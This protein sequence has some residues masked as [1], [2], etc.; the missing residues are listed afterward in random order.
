MALKELGCWN[1]LHKCDSVLYFCVFGE[2]HT[3]THKYVCIH[4]QKMLTNLEI[5][6]GKSDQAKLVPPT[7][8]L[9]SGYFSASSVP[10]IHLL[11]KSK[12]C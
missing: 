11:L 5:Q 3:H 6:D 7:L 1:L 12:F 9:T 2:K 10:N 8:K 4:I